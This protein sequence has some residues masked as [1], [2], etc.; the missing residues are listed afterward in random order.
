MLRSL[1]IQCS[2]CDSYSGSSVWSGWG[3]SGFV[4]NAQ[5]NSLIVFV[6]LSEVLI[7]L[8]FVLLFSLCWRVVPPQCLSLRNVVKAFRNVLRHL[9]MTRV[10]PVA[11]VSVIQFSVCWVS[12]FMPCFGFFHPLRLTVTKAAPPLSLRAEQQLSAR[13]SC[14]SFF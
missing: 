11:F 2:V 14:D 5:F 4:S 9:K 8:E 10:C 1:F 7:T 3:N 13:D 12:F 6:K